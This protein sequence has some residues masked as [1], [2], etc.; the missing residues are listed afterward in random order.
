MRLEDA[1]TVLEC[2]EHFVAVLN[3][4]AAVRKGEGTREDAV[5]R[6]KDLLEGLTCR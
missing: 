3:L 1:I 6:L 5:E 2:R 4:S